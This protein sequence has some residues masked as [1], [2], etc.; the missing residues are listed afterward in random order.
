MVFLQ[1]VMSLKERR[2]V[3]GFL[4][5]TQKI[6]LI[7]QQNLLSV[8]SDDN[9]ST[10]IYFCKAKFYVYLLISSYTFCLI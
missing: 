1:K 8:Y 2:W 6:L 10:K 9:I 4:F 5:G 3:L 7:L